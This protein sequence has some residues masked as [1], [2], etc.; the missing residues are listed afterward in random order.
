MFICYNKKSLPIT[1]IL[2]RK[3]KIIF[4][5]NS[6]SCPPPHLSTDA[7]VSHCWLR[8]N[9]YLPAGRERAALGREPSEVRS[10]WCDSMGQGTETQVWW[11]AIGNG[12]GFCLLFHSLSYVTFFVWSLLLPLWPRVAQ[13][14]RNPPDIRASGLLRR[15]VLFN[16]LPLQNIW[17]TE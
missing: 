14:S 12:K 8:S 17:G 4:L 15:C 11:T 6:V 5:K 1:C 13:D 10:I 7:F 3:V 16:I 9:L 2:F